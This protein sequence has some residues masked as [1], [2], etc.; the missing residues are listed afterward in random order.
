MEVEEP[1]T[2]MG[3]MFINEEEYKK[4]Q[5]IKTTNLIFRLMNYLNSVSVCVKQERMQK[6]KKKKI[7]TIYLAISI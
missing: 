3:I 6:P 1:L 2:P 7:M 5:L 4:K